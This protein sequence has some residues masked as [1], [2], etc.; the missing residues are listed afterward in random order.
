MTMV[1]DI[2]DIQT[3]LEYEDEND[4]FSAAVSAGLA[5][6]KFNG[7]RPFDGQEVEQ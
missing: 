3:R 5:A 2:N 4:T 1:N 6:A 7:F